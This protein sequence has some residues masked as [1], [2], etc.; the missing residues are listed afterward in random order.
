MK[1]L[2][3]LLGVL[4]LVACTDQKV[5]NYNTAR[6][7]VVEDYLRNHKYVKPSENLDKLIEE[8]KIEYAEQ[9]VSLEK[10]AKQWERE[11]TQ[12]QQ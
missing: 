2:A 8:G 5:V 6:L 4:S 10:E 11:K 3:I 12:P 7:D 1:K 9:Y